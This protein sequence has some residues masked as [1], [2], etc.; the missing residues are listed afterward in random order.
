MSRFVVI[1]AVAV[2]TLASLV[3][4]ATTAVA[5][6]SEKASTGLVQGAFIG[7]Y[8]YTGVPTTWFSYGPNPTATAMAILASSQSGPPTR[9]VAEFT[10]PAPG[11]SGPIRP[12]SRPDL[13]LTSSYDTGSTAGKLTPC[14]TA[15]GNAHQTFQ[16]MPTGYIR[17]EGT[18]SMVLD[19]MLNF[20]S[21]GGPNQNAVTIDSSKLTPVPSPPAAL[22]AQVMS[23]DGESMAAMVGG[24][25]EPGA[26]ITIT[27]PGDPITTTV[28]DDG[29]WSANVP[30]LT[31]GENDL[32]ATQTMGDD[33]QTAP[34]TVMIAPV[35]VVHPAVATTALL[36]LAALTLAVVVRR[37]RVT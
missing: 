22:T 27:G 36:S 8:V 32:M 29:S 18:G 16:I 24:T 10:F 30:G 14:G 19:Y 31:D 1:V 34:L 26:T 2:L 12:V 13:C 25:G 3:G 17:V 33:T 37:R 28:A 23:I 9:P 21:T 6:S 4:S 11:T 35:P 15:T 5:A 7:K 20:V